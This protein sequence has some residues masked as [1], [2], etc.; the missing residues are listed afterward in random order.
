MNPELRA[1]Y[2]E[3]ILDHGKH[4]RCF[5]QLE[6]HTHTR[7]GFNPV[8]GDQLTLFLDVRDEHI[9][10]ISFQGQGCAISMASA[11][12]MSQALKGLSLSAANQLFQQF[13]L[14]LTDPATTS[15]EHP[16]LKVFIGVKSYPNRVKCATLAWHTLES[17]LESI[18]A[19]Q[20]VDA[21]NTDNTS[22][23]SPDPVSTE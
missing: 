16:K 2:Q 23:I 9:H 22:S 19:C 6:P 13:H 14:A 10:D 1:L 4:P 17:L 21:H 15:L 8:C 12:M 11:S 18:Q 20:N 7:Q 5:K 3:T